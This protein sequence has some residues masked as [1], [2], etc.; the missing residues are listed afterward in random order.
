MW[1]P[2]R[3]E[4]QELVITCDGAEDDLW[5]WRRDGRFARKANAQAQGDKMHKGL[6]AD[7]QLLHIGIV[8]TVGQAPRK[9]I[10]KSRVALALANDQVFIAKVLPSD[11]FPSSQGMILRKDNENPFIPKSRNITAHHIGRIQ[12]QC[13]IQTPPSYQRDVLIRGPLQNLNSDVGMV[14]AIDLYQFPKKA[15]PHR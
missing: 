8:I 4:L 9:A 14:R 3:T 2:C 1:Q 13:D 15:G 5:K 10:A 6:A 11:L 12:N 7:I